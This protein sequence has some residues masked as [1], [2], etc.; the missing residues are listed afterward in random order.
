MSDPSA[1]FRDQVRLA[2]A[3]VIGWWL[4]WV[5]V[6]FVCLLA[7]H[8]HYGH[9]PPGWVGFTFLSAWGL[10]WNLGACLFSRRACPQCGQV[11]KWSRIWEPRVYCQ[12]CGLTTTANLL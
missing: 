7:Y 2:K 10:L 9:Q 3:F 5:P 11:G 8:A 6:G 4:S 12:N 1:Q